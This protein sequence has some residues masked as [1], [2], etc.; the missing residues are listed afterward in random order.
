MRVMNGKSA[1]V[2]MGDM[3]LR[4]WDEKGVKEND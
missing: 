4:G 2:M 3:R 1:Y